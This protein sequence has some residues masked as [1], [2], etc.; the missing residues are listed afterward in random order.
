MPIVLKGLK[1]LNLGAINYQNPNFH[2]KRYIW[3]VGFKSERPY[4]SMKQAGLREDRETEREKR[5]EKNHQSPQK[6]H[7][8]YFLQMFVVSTPM[9]LLSTTEMSASSSNPTKI[10]KNQ[11][12]TPLP[13]VPGLK[14][15]RE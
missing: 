12:S 11:S 5:K 2:A 14:L 6:L 15:G 4:Y 9:K 13:P 3:P 1:I 10:Q 7:H 8:S